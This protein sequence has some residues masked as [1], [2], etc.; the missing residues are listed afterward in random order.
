MRST[1]S[2]FASNVNCFQVEFYFTTGKSIAQVECGHVTLYKTIKFFVNFA[3]LGILK[4]SGQVIWRIRNQGIEFSPATSPCCPVAPHLPKSRDK[5]NN[6]IV[7]NIKIMT[8][9]NEMK[10]DIKFDFSHFD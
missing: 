8:A 7:P 10:N 2:T 4:A 6:C 5:C 9:G 3:S 1:V